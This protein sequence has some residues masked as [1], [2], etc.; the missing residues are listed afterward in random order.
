MWAAGSRQLLVF[1]VAQRRV[2]AWEC[3]VRIVDTLKL[4]PNGENIT[5]NTFCPFPLRL[6][7][8]LELTRSGVM[9]DWF[10]ERFP[11]QPLPLRSCRRQDT[12]DHG[13]PP[14]PYLIIPVYHYTVLQAMHS[15][16]L[17]QHEGDKLEAGL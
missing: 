11:G 6:K 3:V 14:G 2:G 16:E 1:A 10:N 12:R 15:V 17:K 7:N 9:K 8:R 13:Y 5:F 4:I